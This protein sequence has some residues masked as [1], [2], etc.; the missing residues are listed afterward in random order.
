LN[1]RDIYCIGLGLYWGEGY[2]T[3]NQEF[4][5]TNS[6]PKMVCF[7]I[8]WLESTFGVKK[9][10][11]MSIFVDSEQKVYWYIADEEI[12]ETSLK[13]IILRQKLQQTLNRM[14][15]ICK[16]G[17]VPLLPLVFRN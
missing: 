3:G 1:S 2:K 12:K 16:R 7:Y 9:S 14:H 4:G 5:F 11:L 15:C 13:E 17:Q 8:Y 10:E 6:D